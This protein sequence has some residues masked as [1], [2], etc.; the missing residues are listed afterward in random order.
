MKRLILG[1]VVVL[2]AFV[3][4]ALAG[5]CPKLVAEIQTSTANRFDSTAYDAKVKG[6]AA[7]KLHADGK[8]AESEK[9]AKEA[10][11]ALGIKK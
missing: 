6:A 8:H 3:T 7:A 9:A 10:L 5:Q 4:P 11:A 2:M 1:S